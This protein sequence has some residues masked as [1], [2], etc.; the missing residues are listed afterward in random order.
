MHGFISGL[1]ILF[2]WSICLFLCKYYTVCSILFDYYRFYSLESG[3]MVPPGLFFFLKI[4]L[5]IGLLWFRV[6]FR[7]ICSSSVKN[8]MG[9]LVGILLN[10]Q[11][12]LGSMDIFTLCMV[13]LMNRSQF[14][15]SQI[16]QPFLSWLVLFM[17]CL[18]NPSLSWA[19]FKF[20]FQLMRSSCTWTLHT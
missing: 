14:E 12:A 18:R 11:I 10:L 15:C 9:I 2:H 17:S 6:N 20:L 5:A 1:S 8:V 19:Y 16:Y 7:I 4:T 13:S 3:S